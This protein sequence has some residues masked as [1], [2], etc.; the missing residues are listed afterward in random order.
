MTI[1]LKQNQLMVPPSVQRQAGLKSGD[2][3]KFDV[4]P[5]SIT[6]TVVEPP[7]YKPTKAE[8]AAIS[9]GEQALARGESVSLTE[10][11]HDLDNP[12]RKASSKASPKVS[13]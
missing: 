8:L 3:L 6:I 13:R 4:S 2:R 1:T 9:K 5:R 11:L 10:F 12:R 7:A